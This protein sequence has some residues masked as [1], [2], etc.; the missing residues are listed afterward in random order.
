MTLMGYIFE[1]N[2]IEII[3]G[4]G[5]RNE[6]RERGREREKRIEGDA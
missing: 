3:D 5:A 4:S 2:L 1:I 6:R